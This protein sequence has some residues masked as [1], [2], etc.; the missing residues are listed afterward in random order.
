MP[1]A[2]SG[3]RATS[4]LSSSREGA[5][6]GSVGVDEGL[7]ASAGR[8]S[9]NARAARDMGGCL[10]RGGRARGR[11]LTENE[12]QLQLAELLRL[13]ARGGCDRVGVQAAPCSLSKLPASAL[14]Q[15]GVA[16]RPGAPWTSPYSS[17]P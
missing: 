4:W 13:R 9:A 7:S 3:R 1:V 12:S 11:D 6:A 8:P 17:A 16:T 10:G 14:D 5:G 15:G 2:G